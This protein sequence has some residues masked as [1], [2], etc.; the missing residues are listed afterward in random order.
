MKFK[1]LYKAYTSKSS[2]TIT[3]GGILLLEHL[4]AEE[5]IT[6]E[7]IKLFLKI[8]NTKLKKIMSQL[9]GNKFIEITKDPVDGRR[10][11]VSISK[12]GKDYLAKEFE[13]IVD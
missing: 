8:S 9:E 13:Y 11:L 5:V 2:L 1:T 6:I 3:V 12:K 7:E 10:K 4:S